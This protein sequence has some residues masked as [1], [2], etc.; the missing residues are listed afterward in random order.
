MAAIFEGQGPLFQQCRT[1]LTRIVAGDQELCDLL[2]D[3]FTYFLAMRIEDASILESR[4]L[5]PALVW[6]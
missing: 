5:K 2:L 3:Q 1:P 4:K 6:S